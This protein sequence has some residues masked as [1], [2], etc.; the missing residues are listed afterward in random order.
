MLNKASVGELFEE[1]FQMAMACAQKS[2]FSKWLGGDFTKV[3]LNSDGNGYII[4]LGVKSLNFDVK[5]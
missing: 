5:I 4:G 1:I 3:Y 2:Q